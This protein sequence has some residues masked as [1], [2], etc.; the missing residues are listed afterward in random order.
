[1]EVQAVATAGRV[2]TVL[3]GGVQFTGALELLPAQALATAGRATTAVM[4]SAS[5]RTQPTCT[6]LPS[7]TAITRRSLCVSRGC[8]GAFGVYAMC[9]CMCCVYWACVVGA[10][11]VDVCERGGRHHTWMPRRLIVKSMPH[12]S[13]Q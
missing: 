7:A 11:V 1:M 10:G 3:H 2:T 6:F 9:V 13:S 5:I 12:T 4:G 8:V